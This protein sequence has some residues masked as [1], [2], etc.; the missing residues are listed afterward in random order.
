M[1][2]AVTLVAEGRAVFYTLSN[3]DNAYPYPGVYEWQP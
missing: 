1:A 3:L 2:E